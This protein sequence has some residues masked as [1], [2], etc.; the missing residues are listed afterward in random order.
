[1]EHLNFREEKAKAVEQ[2]WSFL[3]GRVQQLDQTKAIINSMGDQDTYWVKQVN[4]CL[5]DM[6]QLNYQSAR[7]LDQMSS[8]N[9]VEQTQ[10][11]QEYIMVLTMCETIEKKINKILK[12]VSE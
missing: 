3:I 4:D 2:L 11:A 8:P 9:L 7:L 12:S 5:H 1:M 6:E 10:A